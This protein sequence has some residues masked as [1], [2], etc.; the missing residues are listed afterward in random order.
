M[1]ND[2]HH[3]PFPPPL[4]PDHH[5]DDDEDGHE[6]ADG[7]PPAD[8]RPEPCCTLCDGDTKDNHWFTENVCIL[9]QMSAHQVSYILERNEKARRDLIRVTT[10]EELHLLAREVP[11]LNPMEEDDVPMKAQSKLI[12][13]GPFY[14]LFRGNCS[15]R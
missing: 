4:P 8:C 13:A 9:D 10:N 14:T 1:P 7:C 2:P 5:P 12:G 6:G 3:P 15:N 11:R